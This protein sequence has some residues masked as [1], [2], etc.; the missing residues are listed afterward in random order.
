MAPE[1]LVFA[2]R[3]PYDQYLARYRQADLF[4]DTLPFNGGTTVSDALWAGLP[5]LTQV[6]DRFA[7]RMA[8]SLLDAV[9]LPELITRSDDEYES[10]ALQLA[11]EPE[12]LPTYRARLVAARTT[13]ALFD[14]RRFTRHLEQAFTTMWARHQNGDAPASFHVAPLAWPPATPLARQGSA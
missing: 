9:G 14:T 13:S 8:A 11:S 7:G 4:L 6:G 5:V 3:R 12:L 2:E 1:R 10:L